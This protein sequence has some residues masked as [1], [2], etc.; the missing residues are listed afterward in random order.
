MYRFDC[1]YCEGAHPKVL[2]KWVE[3]NMEQ[4]PGYGNDDHCARAREM[5]K[6]ACKAPNAQVHFLVGG[7]QANTVAI[8]AALRPHQGVIAADSGHINVHETGA[9]EATGHKVLA[10]PTEDG[11]LD[12]KKVEELCRLHYG[13]DGREHTVQ[14]KMIYISSPTEFGGIYTRKELEQLGAICDAYGLYLFLDGARLA[15]GLTAEGNDL[16]LPALAQL[17]DIFYLGGTK[18]GAYFGEALVVSNPEL[19]E[20]FRY[21]IKQRG[22]MFAKGRLLGL[23]FEALMEDDLYLHIG[24]KPVE[25]AQQIRKALEQKGCHLLVESPTNQLFVVM[26]DLWLKK[27]Q[28]KYTVA[29]W[30]KVDENHTAVRF[31]TSWGTKQEA[32]DELIQDILAL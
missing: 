12:S 10:I 16:D 4:H 5:I 18:V 11:K 19:Q 32:V 22:G 29:F 30:Q 23:Q 27:L 17:C 24:K 2:Q 9:I 14:P 13:D 20:D 28:E 6:E 15:Y 7:T 25:Q 31:C 26:P 21:H 3:T 1:D 8:A